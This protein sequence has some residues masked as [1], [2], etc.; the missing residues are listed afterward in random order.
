MLDW[1]AL[2]ILIVLLATAVGGALLLGYLPGKIARQRSHPQAE[3][4]SVCGWI[5][6][7][8]G[9]LLLPIAYV[10]AYWQFP[11]PLKREASA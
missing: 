7:L 3:A 4:V 6:L 2:F 8:S 10:W 9:G 1:F 5:G 11:Q